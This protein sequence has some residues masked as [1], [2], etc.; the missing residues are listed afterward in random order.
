[1]TVINSFIIVLV[2][3]LL[4]YSLYRLF[5]KKSLLMVIPA[6][7]QVFS[8][9]I[10]ILSL[11]HDVEVPQYIE[12]AYILLG[13]LPPS[14]FLF[15]DYVRMIRKVKSRGIYEGLVEQPAKTA[16]VPA[17]LPPEGINEPAK[18]KQIQDV[19][20]DLKN[21]PDDI[22]KNVR[23]CLGHAHALLGEN[24]LAGPY[25]IYS[26][27]AKI[28]G[29]SYMLY[30]NWAC[31]CYRLK[32]YEEVLENCK[33]ALELLNGTVSEQQDILYNMGNAYYMLDNYGSAARSF[34]KV[35]EVNGENVQSVEN[36]AFTY[37]HMGEKEKGI[38]L[39]SNTKADPG[40]FRAHFI[41]GRLLHEAG[42]YARAEEELR[43]SARLRPDSIEV[44]EELGRVLM[45][46]E[47]NEAALEVFDEIL[48]LAPDHYNTWSNKAHVNSKLGSWKEAAA[49][50]KEAVRIRP[51][52][53]ISYYNMAIALQECGNSKAAADAFKSAIRINPG[54]V[55]AYN[56]LG[57]TLSLA[58][59][60]EEALE[61]Y[62]EG[63]KR[64]PHDFSLFFNMGMSL[65]ET[66]K[67]MEAA[68]AYRDALDLKPDELEIYYYLGAALTEIRHYNDAIEAY[69]SALDIKPT[70][71]ELHYNIAAIYA[72]LGRYDIAVENLKHAIE[73][74]SEVRSDIMQNRAFDGMRSR[75][76]FKE[77]IS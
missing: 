29:S 62:E 31:I 42:E 23:K 3:L 71:G 68:A 65:F 12:L 11:I 7:A 43:K 51:D 75:N 35:L 69:K 72:M 27:C 9:V 32:K 54:F 10:A 58:G 2:L 73:L 48:K 61:V 52:S 26:T 74:D 36:L 22:Q 34:E 76:D 46:Q 53:S 49:S 39:L 77:M 5:R 50:Y 56:N 66:G 64:N 37:V 30:Y 67:H 59:R 19:M 28:A 25:Y 15:I 70:D 60:Y 33:K 41:S 17:C 38:E 45:K 55:A 57:I 21:L 8:L 18:E 24:D 40:N 13:I 4:I 63:I 6:C 20:K 47:K 16:P 14:V 1:M 44:L